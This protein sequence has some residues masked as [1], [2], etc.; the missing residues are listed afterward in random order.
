MKI[1]F[2][3]VDQILDVKVCNDQKDEWSKKTSL[4]FLST[5][6]VT[7]DKTKLLNA[8]VPNLGS[9]KPTVGFNKAASGVRQRSP[10]LQKFGKRLWL[11]TNNHLQN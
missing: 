11:F 8:V 9:I 5:A 1:N 7:L 2:T 6:I 10:E 3:T 4:L